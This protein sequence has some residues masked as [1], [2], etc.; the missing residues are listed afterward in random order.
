MKI[1]NK[2]DFSVGLI[3]FL[4]GIVGMFDSLLLSITFTLFELAFLLGGSFQLLMFGLLGISLSRSE[5]NPSSSKPKS[6][7]WSI[8]EFIIFYSLGI[9]IILVQIL[10]LKIY[11]MLFVHLLI[12]IN[13]LMFGLGGLATCNCFVI[14]KSSKLKD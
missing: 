9:G 2:E 6:M 8:I 14:R 3:F 11:N 4:A 1:N 13:I 5:D 10:N 7:K 12:P